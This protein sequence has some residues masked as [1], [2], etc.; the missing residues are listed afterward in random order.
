MVGRGWG[1]T[2]GDTLDKATL[3]GLQMAAMATARVLLKVS[4]DATFPGVR[5][6][7]AEMQ[8]QLE[9]LGLDVALKRRG[10]WDLV[11]GTDA[12]K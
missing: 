8:A 2:E 10:T 5:R 7:K 1:H 6:S 3:R 12:T 11:G 4:G 9:E